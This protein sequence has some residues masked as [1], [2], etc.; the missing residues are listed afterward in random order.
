M[1]VKA[2]G[3]K[4]ISDAAWE[5][6]WNAPRPRYLNFLN[7]FSLECRFLNWLPQ[8]QS[9]SPLPWFMSFYTW[10]PPVSAIR[11]VLRALFCFPALPSSRTCR[12]SRSIPDHSSETF[13]PRPGAL[14]RPRWWSTWWVWSSRAS[15]SHTWEQRFRYMK[16]H[17]V[18]SSRPTYC[19]LFYWT[20][21]LIFIAA[22]VS[23]TWFSCG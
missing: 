3:L 14:Q 10:L 2:S 15:C 11:S 13:P 12:H 9:W 8:G 1:V 22:Q 18:L 17:I 4:S 20:F 19:V 5:R 7:S 16:G 23:L 21:N 6:T